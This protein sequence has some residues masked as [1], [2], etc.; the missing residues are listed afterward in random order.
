MFQTKL[1][2]NLCLIVNTFINTQ[3]T[4]YFLNRQAEEAESL[5]LRLEEEK[6][7]LEQASEVLKRNHEQEILKQMSD[8][9]MMLQKYKEDLLLQQQKSEVA[10]QLFFPILIFTVVDRCHFHSYYS[11]F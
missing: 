8:R 6:Q 5:K 4:A 7:K 11:F 2:S 1:Y 3:G 10:F 9:E